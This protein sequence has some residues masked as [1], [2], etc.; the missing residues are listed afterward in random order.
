VPSRSFLGCSNSSSASDVLHEL[1][2]DAFEGTP[3]TLRMAM[4]SPEI[5]N[6]VKS[7]WYGAGGSSTL[8]YSQIPTIG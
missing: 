3:D 6:G 8:G 4:V 5:V 7:M 1:Y 2:L